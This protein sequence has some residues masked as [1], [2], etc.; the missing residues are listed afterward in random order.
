MINRDQHSINFPD[1]WT[2]VRRIGRGGQAIAVHIRHEDGRHGV[3]RQLQRRLSPVDIERFRR[4]LEI[5]SE[6]VEHP[7]IVTLWDWSSEG[8]DFWYISELGDSFTSWWRQRIQQL[9]DDPV[10][11]VDEAIRTIRHVAS[12]LAEC[13]HN[14]IVHRDLKPQNLVMKKEVLDPWPILIDFGL[15]HDEVSERLTPMDGAVGNAKFSPDMMRRR[16]EEVSPWSDVFGLAQILIWMLDEGSPKQHWQRPVAWDYAVYDPAIPEGKEQSIRAFT[17]SCS[18][19]TSGPKNGQEALNLM[20]RLFPVQ[21]SPQDGGI[22]VSAIVEAKRQGAAKMLLVEAALDAEVQSSAPLAE[23][24][25]RELRRS[26]VD[27]LDEISSYDPTAQVVFD[28]PFHHK[29]IGATDLF[30]VSVGPATRN[31]Q[32]RIKTKIVPV[33]ETP[34]SNESNRAFWR[35]HIPD[36]AVCFTFALEGGVPQAGNKRYRDCRWITLRRDGATYMHPLGGNLGTSYSDNDLGGSAEGPGTI[37]TME[38]IREFIGSVFTNPTFW[39]FIA[40]TG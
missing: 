22:D 23:G 12:A 25:Y 37:C 35:K 3:L 13:H 15:A 40:E 34:T 29:L 20:D 16:T 36:D 38:D 32:L 27:V 14:G 6:R 5:L 18:N 2:E 9:E 26:V 21:P 8:Q 39:E 28:R 19:Q 1:G 31:I 4:E 11:L 24:I 7:G 17:A 10:S 33:N 30:Q